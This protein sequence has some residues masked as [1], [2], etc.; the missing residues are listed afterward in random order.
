MKS[1]PQK[2][3]PFKKTSHKNSPIKEKSRHKKSLKVLGT[4]SSDLGHTQYAL[5]TTLAF[6]IMMTNPKL[7]KKIY[8][9]RISRIRLGN[10]VVSPMSVVNPRFHEG[11]LYVTEGESRWATQPK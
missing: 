4:R 5:S 2:R 10:R 9:Q 3:V 6:G 1:I 8:T 7:I 11:R